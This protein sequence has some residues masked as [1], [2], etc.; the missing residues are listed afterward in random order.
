VR[1][2]LAAG[3]DIEL[4]AQLPLSLLQNWRLEHDAEPDETVA[5]RIVR[6]FYTPGPGRGKT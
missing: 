6:Q 4:L 2:E 1:G 5:D 3:S